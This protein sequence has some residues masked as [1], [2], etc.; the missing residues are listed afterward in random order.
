M[1]LDYF[2]LNVSQNVGQI[3]KK[4]LSLLKEILSAEYPEVQRLDNGGYIF[5]NLNEKS[6]FLILPNQVSANFDKIPE[7]FDF[8]SD[9]KKPLLQ[10][11][12]ALIFEEEV[13]ASARFNFLKDTSNSFEKS[14]DLIDNEKKKSK[15]NEK[16]IIGTGYR[17][18]RE[19]QFGGI[20]EIKIEPLIDDKSKWF[21]ESIININND[22]NINAVLKYINEEINSFELEYDDLID[23]YTN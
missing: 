16:G 22:T 5:L 17:F 6:N 14:L 11:F 4:K 13:K 7:T 10:I 3:S 23:L 18:L 21:I 15:L 19:G 12:E 2:K 20:S 8:N 9:V 1:N